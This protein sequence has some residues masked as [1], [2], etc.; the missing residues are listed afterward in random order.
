MSFTGAETGWHRQI[1][2]KGKWRGWHIESSFARSRL[3][4]VITGEHWEA[5]FILF[6]LSLFLI[7]DL[8]YL[9]F[10]STLS[11][12][13]EGMMASLGWTDVPLIQD[14]A[15]QLTCLWG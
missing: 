10:N 13:R 11:G 14:L 3:D 7:Y 9:D 2:E 8:L 1:R 4:L 5:L 15:L 12:N 6:S